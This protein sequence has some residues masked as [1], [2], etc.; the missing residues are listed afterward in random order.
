MRIGTRRGTVDQHRDRRFLVDVVERFAEEERLF[1]RDL[2]ILPDLVGRA[3]VRDAPVTSA[4][5]DKDPHRLLRET[6]VSRGTKTRPARQF[7]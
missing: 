6:V 2:G 7:R 5:A 1:G 3:A 4:T